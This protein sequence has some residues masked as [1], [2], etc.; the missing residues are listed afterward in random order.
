MNPTS[1]TSC[2]YS[3]RSQSWIMSLKISHLCKFFFWVRT[4]W[5][6]GYMALRA[7]EQNVGWIE[8][9]VWMD[10]WIL[11]SPSKGL[12]SRPLWLIQH[13]W[14]WY[15]CVKNFKVVPR[16]QYCVIHINTIMAIIMN[17][18][19]NSKTFHQRQGGCAWPPHVQHQLGLVRHLGEKKACLF[20]SNIF[21]SSRREKWILFILYI[22]N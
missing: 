9:T 3:V 6:Y 18:F 20:L 4:P 21:L 14:C 19:A 1:V 13:L 5:L 17:Y 16:S 12:R 10:R 8:W 7:S 15:I 22:E 2:L 11:D